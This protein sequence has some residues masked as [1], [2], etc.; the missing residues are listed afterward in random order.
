MRIV[1]VTY[2]YWPAVGGV[3][4]YMHRLSQALLGK[5]HQVDLVCAAHEDG[6]PTSEIHEGVRVHRFPAHRSPMRCWFDLMM[7]R[8]LFCDA[9]VIHISD[10][11]VLEYFYRML[12]WTMPNKP[13]HVR[14]RCNKPCARLTRTTW[15][16]VY[17]PLKW[18]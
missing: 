18:A 6:L 9:D 12:A 11:L 13:L 2:R 4:K 5:G 10:T 1:F 14:W 16:G 7:K 8:K 3:E 17:P 15:N